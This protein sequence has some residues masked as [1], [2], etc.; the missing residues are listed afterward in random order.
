[1]KLLLL[2]LALMGSALLAS[3]VLKKRAARSSEPDAWPFY[4]KKPLSGP[5]QVL[6]HRLVAAL[7][8]HIVLAQVQVSRVLGVKK[9]QNFSHWNNRINRMSYDFV[10][11]AKDATV[12]AAI[13][14]DD[15]THDAP[16]RIEADTKK[17][18]ATQAAGIQLIRWH[19]KTLPDHDAIRYAIAEANV[20]SVIKPDLVRNRPPAAPLDFK[21]SS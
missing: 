2:V 17:E 1:M 14:L 6:Y 16:S 21:P 11:C 3:I 19:V 18:Q 9:G 20:P 15:K 7:P 5:E 8:E 4:K 12:I 10:V 13:E